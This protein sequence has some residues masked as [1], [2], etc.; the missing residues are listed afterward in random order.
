M[1]AC[2]Y[3][4]TLAFLSSPLH[5]R[6]IDSSTEWRGWGEKKKTVEISADTAGQYGY[7]GDGFVRGRGLMWLIPKRGARVGCDGISL[8][9]KSWPGAPLVSQ[10]IVRKTE[11]NAI[12]DTFFSLFLLLFCLVFLPSWRAGDCIFFVLFMGRNDDDVDSKVRSTW[13][14]IMWGGR[15]GY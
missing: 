8:V 1:S 12:V 14:K 3:N 2:V 7:G 9:I 4:K 11:A 6:L 5:C 10:S 15:E 13:W